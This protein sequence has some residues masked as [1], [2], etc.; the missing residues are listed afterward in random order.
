MDEELFKRMQEAAD[1]FRSGETDF[2]EILTPIGPAHLVRDESDPRGFRIDFVGGG[3][4]GVVPVQHYP[5][6]PTR[7]PGWPAPIPFLANCAAVVDTRAQSVTWTEPPDPET[8]LARLV[9][10]SED[11]GWSPPLREAPTGETARASH[12]VL[13]KD[14]A[15]RTLALDHGDDGIRIVLRERRLADSSKPG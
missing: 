3:S 8:A 7:P 9:R 11:D 12:H 13:E 14:G 1:R 15:E 2:E 4:T 10:Q 6:A 5:P